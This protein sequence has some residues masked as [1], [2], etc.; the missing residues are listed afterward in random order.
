MLRVDWRLGSGV[1]AG[2]DKRKSSDAWPF[3]QPVCM[4]PESNDGFGDL[5]LGFRFG[6]RV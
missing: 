3:A 5:G 4:I 2:V 1:L 6:F